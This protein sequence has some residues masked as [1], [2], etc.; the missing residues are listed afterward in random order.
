MQLSAIIRLIEECEQHPCAAPNVD[1]VADARA[2]LIAWQSSTTFDTATVT[3]AQLAECV[4]AL[5]DDLHGTA[6]HGLIG[7]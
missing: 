3:T 4:K 5:I 1:I 6:G 2:E 7:T